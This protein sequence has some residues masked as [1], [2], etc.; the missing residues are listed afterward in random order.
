[1]ANKILIANR[2]E[3]SCRGGASALGVIDTVVLCR[4]A[5]E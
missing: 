5:A 3:I 4:E 2:H 1:M